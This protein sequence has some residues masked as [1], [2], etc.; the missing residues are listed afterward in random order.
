MRAGD[1]QGKMTGFRQAL[2]WDLAPPQSASTDTAGHSSDGRVPWGTRDALLVASGFAAWVTLVRYVL[3]TDVGR[4]L[5]G[6]G[7]AVLGPLELAFLVPVM[8]LVLH[9]YGVGLWSLGFKRFPGR[10]IEHGLA[11]LVAVFALNCCYTSALVEIRHVSPTGGTNAAGAMGNLWLAVLGGAVLA[12]FAEEVLFR[13][14]VYPGLSARIGN[15]GAALAS[16]GLFALVHLRWTAVPTLFALGFGLC[17][18]YDHYRSVWPPVVVHALSN[19]F[20]LGVGLLARLPS[21]GPVLPPGST[22]T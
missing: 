21:T 12:P 11:L 18:L 15:L 4:R 19:A 10:A 22:W 2:S 7:T 9:K 20:V 16:S 3:A 6:D 14:F 1:R 8:W 13:S 17:M 5:A